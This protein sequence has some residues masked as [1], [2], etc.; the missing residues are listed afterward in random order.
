MGT[1]DSDPYPAGTQQIEV[2]VAGYPGNPGITLSVLTSDGREIALATPQPRER[3]QRLVVEVPAA[4][5]DTGFRIRLRDQA[6]GSFGWAGIGTSSI[7]ATER[8]AAGLLPLLATV[9]LGNVWLLA[10]AMAVPAPCSS[11]ERLLHGLLAAGCVWLL[12]F[13]IY[14]LSVQWGEAA[15]LAALVA[16]LPVCL[17]AG[18]RRGT[19]AADL[20]GMQR[21]LLP[22]LLF[23]TLILWVG[24]FPFH[25]EGYTGDEPAHR[26]HSLAIDNWL[27]LLFGDMLARGRLDVPMTADW[28]S[29]DRPPLQ[30]GLYLMMRG[31]LPGS[32]GLVYQ[33]ASTWAQALV[34]LPVGILLRR[35]LDR[36]GTAIA[37]FT[38]SLSAL[39]VLNTLYVWPKLLAAAYCLIYYLSL[40]GQRP[41]RRH[42]LTAGLSAALALLAHGGALFFL[43]GTSLLYLAWY[44]RQALATLVRAGPI[45]ILLYMPW[46]AYQKLIDPPGDRLIK[47]H[48][49]GKIAVSDESALHAISSAYAQLTPASWFASRMQNVHTITEGVLRGPV[50]AGRILLRQDPAAISQFVDN[51]FF[52]LF[53]SMW[54]TSPLLL[55]PWLAAFYAKPSGKVYPFA[56]GSTASRELLQVLAV[57]ATTLLVWIVALF[58]GGSTVVHHGAYATFLLLQLAVVVACRWM[59]TLLF[60]CVCVGNVAVAL[61]VYAFDRH[62]LPSLQPVY[63]AGTAFLVGALLLAVCLSLER[64]PSPPDSA[65]HG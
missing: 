25:W 56:H 38:L 44:R 47:W 57:T 31:L 15:A 48:F 51:S 45:A 29:S 43:V 22:V 17:W 41:N 55:I 24:L 18:L 6:E 62:F 11:Q 63:L 2:M 33:A 23:A 32:Q 42:W 65:G 13:F 26:W 49:A 19:L 3:W 7:G 61:S 16:P 59:S 9:L 5:S 35:L 37:L 60:H 58:D 64:S 53:H 27:P 1:I 39:V 12:L 34:L 50:D 10:L 52:G 30:T 4:A 28:L 20:I 40:F 14:C 46:L 36:R 8:F 54:F 21:L